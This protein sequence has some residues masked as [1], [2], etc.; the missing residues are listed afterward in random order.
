MERVG[1]WE[2]GEEMKEEKECILEGGEIIMQQ[3]KH[4]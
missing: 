4:R 1:R 2:G 3:L